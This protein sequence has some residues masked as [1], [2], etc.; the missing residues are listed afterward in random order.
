MTLVMR[1]NTHPTPRPGDMREDRRETAIP[2]RRF[3]RKQGPQK[4][5]RFVLQ[6]DAKGS[7]KNEW[8]MWGILLI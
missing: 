8:R 5:A 6:Q 3:E 2:L 4:N 1:S 7:S